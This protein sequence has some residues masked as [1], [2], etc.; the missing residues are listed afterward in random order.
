MTPPRDHFPTMTPQLNR[1]P[2]TD[3]DPPIV[4]IA[5]RLT[6][7]RSVGRYGYGAATGLAGAS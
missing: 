5:P 4:R 1:S 3:A 7:R 6:H 2:Q